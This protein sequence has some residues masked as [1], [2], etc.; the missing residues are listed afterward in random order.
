MRFSKLCDKCVLL[1]THYPTK[2]KF[3]LLAQNRYLKFLALNRSYKILDNNLDFNSAPW[4]FRGA[5]RFLRFLPAFFSGG[6]G[7]LAYSVRIS[8]RS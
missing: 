5:F 3:I 6:D 1:L 2:S 4:I 7:L 8:P